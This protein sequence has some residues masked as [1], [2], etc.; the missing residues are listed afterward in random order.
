MKLFFISTNFKTNKRKERF[1]PWLRIVLRH[2]DVCKL[3]FLVLDRVIIIYTRYTFVSTHLALGSPSP[4]FLHPSPLPDTSSRTSLPR[5]SVTAALLSRYSRF[6]AEKVFILRQHACRPSSSS[7]YY[8]TLT[9]QQT[10]TPTTAVWALIKLKNLNVFPDVSDKNTGAERP[11]N[12]TS[13]AATFKAL[14]LNKCVWR[15]QASSHDRP[16][17]SAD[18][19]ALIRV[20]GL[21]KIF[22]SRLFS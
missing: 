13:K 16:S 19:Q 9:P 14:T 15:K 2:G 6:N 8:D 20:Q 22:Y 7:P 17:F 10:P 4:S 3:H 18:V 11:P 21:F 1:V 5:I 12:I